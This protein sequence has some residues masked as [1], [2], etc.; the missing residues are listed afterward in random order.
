MT[1]AATEKRTPKPLN[2]VDTP[3][4]FA[5]INA[6]DGQRDLAKFTFRASNRWERGTHSRARVETFDGA[7]GQHQH[8]RDVTY[9]IDHPKV[10]VAADNGPTPVEFLLLGLSGCLTLGIATVAAARGVEITSIES[11]LEGDIDL[12]GVLGLDKSVRNG[13]QH[14]RVAFDVKGNAPAEKLREI[15]DQ[16]K[17]RSAVYDVLTNGVK[18][19]VDV[20]VGA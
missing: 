20:N 4:L 2:G 17:A 14:V 9:D 12:Q 1:T 3:T 18:V 19:D 7:G 16:S 11:R 5:T 6:V 8:E 13:F 15:V 10:L